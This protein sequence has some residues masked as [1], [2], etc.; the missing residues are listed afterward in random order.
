MEHIKVLEGLTVA[1]ETLGGE[2]IFFLLSGKILK[3][4]GYGHTLSLCFLNYALRLWF[5][6]CLSNPWWIVAVELFMQGPTYAL[7][8]TTIVAYAS[9]I[10]PPGTSA[11]VQGIIAGMDDGV[12]EY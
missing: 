10:A 5:I 11:T 12:G 3:S 6:S 2:I 1:A 8:Y 4:F 9:A 7:C